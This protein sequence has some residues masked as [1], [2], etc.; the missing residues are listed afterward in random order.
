MTMTYRVGDFVGCVDLIDEERLALPVPQR[1]FIAQ[2][3]PNRDQRVVKALQR[4]GVSAWSPTIARYLDRRTG[5][6][7]ARPHLG[8][9]VETPFPGRP[10]LHC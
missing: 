3:T 2:C 5:K 9:R 7:A 4:R 8:R 1:W 10:N 6:P